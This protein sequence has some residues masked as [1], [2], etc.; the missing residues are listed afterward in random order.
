MIARAKEL[1]IKIVMD[2]VPNHCSDQH[3]WFKKSS[4]PNHP[5]YETYKDYFIWNKGKLLENGTRLPPSNW[6]SVFRGSAWTWSESRQEYFFR[7]FMSEQPDLNFR[8]EYVSNEMKEILR[9]WLRKGVDGFR[10][11]AVIFLIE[12]EENADGL[13]NDE[14]LSGTSDDPMF[15]NYLLHNETR[16]LIETYELVNEWRKVLDEPEFASHTR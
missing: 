5:E 14:P 2:F 4:N 16:D 13:Y 3:E 12:T 1:D 10:V 9:F 15:D 11:D 7:N 8:N 6:L